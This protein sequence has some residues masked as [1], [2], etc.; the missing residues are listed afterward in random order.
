MWMRRAAIEFA[1]TALFACRMRQEPSDPPLT[2][3]CSVNSDVSP[4]SISKKIT[5]SGETQLLQ[6]NRKSHIEI[7]SLARLTQGILSFNTDQTILTL[8]PS[9]S[10][11]QASTP[12]A[13]AGFSRAFV[14]AG[15]EK[16]GLIREWRIA[17]VNAGQNN[18]PVAEDCVSTQ[19]RLANKDLALASAAVI[20]DD[21]SSAF[22]CSPLNSTT[23]K[24]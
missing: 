13:K 3:S 7:Q 19:N 8:P 9:D 23:C 5:K 12:Q 1:T 20:A 14:Q 17:I 2:R 15:I 22:R 11:G 21:D 16:I 18:S 6:V 10:N 4:H 24:S